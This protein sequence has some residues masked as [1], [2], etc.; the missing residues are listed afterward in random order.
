MYVCEVYFYK[1][2]F[3]IIINVYLSIFHGG[4]VL[5]YINLYLDSEINLLSV[6][7]RFRE[8]ALNKVGRITT[9]D[10]QI[11]GIFRDIR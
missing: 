2:I 7:T 9:V 6:N 1:I 8:A 10:N 11:K 5:E 3:I 4:E